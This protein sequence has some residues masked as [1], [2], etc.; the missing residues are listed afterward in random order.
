MG[1]ISW[2]VTTRN[3]AECAERGILWPVS[4]T[5]PLRDDWQTL[6]HPSHLSPRHPR[7]DEII[8]RH[9]TAV[10]AGVPTYVDPASGFSVFTAVF[11]E[12]RSYCCESGCRH[13]PYVDD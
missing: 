1:T 8:G 7:F 2:P 4:D 9:D 3:D 6:P 10:A 12:R 5:P 13:C 11:L